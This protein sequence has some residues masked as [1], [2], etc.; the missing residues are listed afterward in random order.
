MVD[1]AILP[2]MVKDS[3]YNGWSSY[4][5]W[6]I[7]LWIQNDPQLYRTAT[8]YILVGSNVLDARGKCHYMFPAGETPDGVK[9]SDPSINWNEIEE[10]FLELVR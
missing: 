4:A 10:M 8:H 6:N 5:T 9:L 7:A 2:H 1:L 3:T